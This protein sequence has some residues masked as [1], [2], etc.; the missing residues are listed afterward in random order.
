M[1]RK[2]PDLNLQTLKQVNPIAESIM[3]L[4]KWPKR[5]CMVAC[6]FECVSLCSL[7]ALLETNV[8][9]MVNIA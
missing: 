7:T 4:R 6:S 2:T 9:S 1:L 5:L 3:W 8:G